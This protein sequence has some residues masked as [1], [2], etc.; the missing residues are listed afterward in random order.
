MRGSGKR[1]QKGIGRTEEAESRYEK[2]SKGGD[3]LLETRECVQGKQYCSARALGE[4]GRV[5]RSD[6]GHR[7]DDEYTAEYGRP[8]GTGWVGKLILTQEFVCCLKMRK[9]HK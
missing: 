3:R 6:S 9:Q 4:R 1:G 7:P 2:V 5:I 8:A